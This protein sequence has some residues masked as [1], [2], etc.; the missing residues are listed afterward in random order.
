[1]YVAKGCD[2]LR[3]SRSLR[4]S[5]FCTQLAQLAVK[6]CKEERKILRL[7]TAEKQIGTVPSLS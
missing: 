3:T 4:S 5:L 1:M 2:W 6:R 7:R